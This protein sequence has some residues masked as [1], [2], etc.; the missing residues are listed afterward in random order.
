MRIDYNVLWVEDQ[1]G[2]VRSTREAV[3]REIRKEGFR[4][5]VQFA[6]SVDE[7]QEY[8]SND[9][10]GD[11]IDLILMDFDLG[12]G[13]K[14]DEGLA[15]IRASFPFKDVIF[16]SAGGAD[17]AKLVADK[18]IQ[19]IFCSDR[20]GL[21]E[22]VVGLFK[23]LL[24]KVVDI[25]HA[26]GI[27]MGSSSEIDGL[28]VDCLSSLFVKSDGTLTSAAIE[29]IS[30]RCKTIRDDFE[31]EMKALA[32]AKTISELCDLHRHY[33]SIDRINLLRKLLEADGKH[34][35]TCTA[36]KSYTADTVPRRNQFAHVR[37]VRNG[38]SR[39]LFDKKGN[40]LT[41]DTVRA[42]LTKLLEHQEALERLVPQL[43][44]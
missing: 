28:I 38:F 7:A 14:G 19:G 42:I 30:K 3:D 17:L 10:Y 25:D 32:G 13:K 12:V 6:K 22:E 33:S 9:I 8:L 15:E 41:A 18:Q 37:V 2:S 34:E 11:H 31:K 16:Y 27:I 4:L 29:I 44:T 20:P 40:E 21:P 23:T 36:I 24:R 39:K 1:P 5:Q 35:V 43:G 26:R